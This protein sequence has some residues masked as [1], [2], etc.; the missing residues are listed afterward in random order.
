RPSSTRSRRN[1]P[2]RRAVRRGSAALELGRALG[3]ERRG[4]LA[5]I[6]GREERRVPGGDVVEAFGDRLALA[7]IEHVLDAAHDQRRVG[8]DLGGPGPRGGVERGA[9]G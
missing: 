2:T 4:G 1:S 7:V 6:L 9:I 8:G 5:E 3:G